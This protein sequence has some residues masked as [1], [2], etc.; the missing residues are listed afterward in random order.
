MRIL[1][2]TPSP[3]SAAA[4]SAVPVVA[5]AQ[6]RAVAARQAVTVFTMAG[7]DPREL[8]ALERLRAAGFDVRA[9]ERRDA[10]AA[11]RAT[12]W[13]RNAVRW[14]TLR[15]PMYVVWHH[16]P[17]LQRMLDTLLREGTFDVVHVNDSA[18]AA[19]TFDTSA[20]KLLV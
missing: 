14:A 7:P 17:A 5:W 4:P 18:M 9:V 10:S 16:E 15:R 12:R 6:V 20:P 2:V 11:D 8:V 1:L 19:Y 3:P 13:L